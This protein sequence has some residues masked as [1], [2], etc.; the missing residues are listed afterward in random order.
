MVRR[1]RIAAVLTLAVINVF[2]L[3]AG[4][5]VA[6]MLPP[7]LAALKVPVVAAGPVMVPHRRP[8]SRVGAAASL[9]V[10][11]DVPDVA[12]GSCGGIAP[13]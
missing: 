5:A 6:R 8:P 9:A 1:T 13:A 7:R 12:A 3:A 2:T 4:I 10:H 11:G